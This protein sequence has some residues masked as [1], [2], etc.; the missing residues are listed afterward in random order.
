MQ[1]VARLVVPYF[2]DW[3]LVDM[4]DSNGQ[5]QRVAYAHYDPDQQ[6]VLKD[7]V[8]RFP[9]DWNSSALSRPGAAQRSAAIDH[10]FQ[11][12]HDRP[13]GQ[14][15]RAPCADRVARSPVVHRRADRDSLTDRRFAG[16]RS[17]A[18]PRGVIRRRIWTWP[19]SCRNVRASRSRMPGCTATSRKRN[20][21]RM[22][23]WR[24]WRTSCAIL[25]RPSNMPTRWPK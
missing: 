20:G 6:A 24:C 21:R 11:R 14:Q 19:W 13:V 4:V 7:F 25:W 10:R 12:G 23:S 1:R 18:P 17:V 2:A 22:I 5:I 8:E 9:P 3:C 16:V 15:R